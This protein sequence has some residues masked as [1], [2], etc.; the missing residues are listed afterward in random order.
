MCSDYDDNRQLT[1]TEHETVKKTR[2]NGHN[3]MGNRKGTR[4]TEA[5]FTPQNFMHIFRDHDC[6]GKF[7]HDRVKPP[8]FARQRTLVRLWL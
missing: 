1:E 7:S 4:P 2:I 3:V 6:C 8:C 5:M